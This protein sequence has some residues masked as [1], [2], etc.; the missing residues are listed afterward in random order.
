MCLTD[1]RSSRKR[2]TLRAIVFDIDGVLADFTYGF[3]AILEGRPRSQGTQQTWEFDAPATEVA[4]T[5]AYID[6]S[7]R[8]WENLTPLI[9]EG[10][11][12]D[13]VYLCREFDLVP[14]YITGREDRGNET[15]K[16]TSRWLTSMGM[17]KGTII[18]NGDKVAALRHVTQAGVEVVAVI[19]DRPQTLAE[20]AHAEYITFA[21]DWAYNRVPMPPEVIRVGSVGE[22][23]TRVRRLLQLEEALKS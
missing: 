19:D 11:V 18:L 14:Y 3:T 17:P 2:E 10:E 21:R 15:L 8:F 6:R 4:R 13:A 5:W 16:Q 1:S 7:T 22:Y 23:V 9:T 20:L 12:G